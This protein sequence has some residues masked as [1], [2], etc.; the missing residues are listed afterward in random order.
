MFAANVKK[1]GEGTCFGRREAEETVVPLEELSYVLDDVASRGAGEE[2]VVSVVDME[3]AVESVGVEAV[4]EETH[5]PLSLQQ[6]SQNGVIECLR[7]V[8]VPIPIMSKSNR[9]ALERYSSRFC[10][11]P[12]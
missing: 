6:N 7:L 10:L 9:G 3:P 12:L 4:V 11:L 5:E 1:V 2:V 8:G